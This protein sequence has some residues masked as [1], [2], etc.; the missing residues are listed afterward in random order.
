MGRARAAAEPVRLLAFAAFGSQALGHFLLGRPHEAA[1]AAY[2]AVQS[3]P[4]HSINYVILIGPLVALD[5]LD[6]ARIAAA[7]VLELQPT[8]RFS[9]QF[10]GV[11]CAPELA[12]K[13]GSALSA[14][15]LSG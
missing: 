6:E 13:L 11:D 2:L 7:R 1:K 4:G 3:N 14:A 5:R 9:R 15:G 8:F 10:A 12:A